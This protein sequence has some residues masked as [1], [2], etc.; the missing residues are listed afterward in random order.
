MIIEWAYSFT[1]LANVEPM[2]ELAHDVLR[3]VQMP[4]EVRNE[5]ISE[6]PPQVVSLYLSDGDIYEPFN[7]TEQVPSPPLFDSWLEELRN[8]FP[9]RN[10]GD[11]LNVDIEAI[12]TDYP[13]S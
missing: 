11:P 2:A 8:R 7:R 1:D 10:Y 5:I 4:L 3:A 12:P 13:R 9:R 6:V